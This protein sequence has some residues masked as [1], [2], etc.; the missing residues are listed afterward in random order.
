MSLI[1]SFRPFLSSLPSF[2]PPF[3]LSFSF[4]PLPPLSSPNGHTTHLQAVSSS[5]R[6]AGR[7]A[8]H[9]A[10]GV[11]PAP[12]QRRPGWLLSQP[13]FQLEAR[14]KRPLREVRRVQG[15]QAAVRLLPPRGGVLALRAPLL[16]RWMP[17]RLTAQMGLLY[18]AANTRRN[19]LEKEKIRWRRF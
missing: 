13:A 5:R 18:S 3:L 9:R 2:L 6:P 10:P 8:R 1:R 15:L 19:G 7:K 16:R 4:P 17:V 14:R 11:L 12:H